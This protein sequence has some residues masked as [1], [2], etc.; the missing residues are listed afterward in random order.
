MN[1]KSIK[2]STVQLPSEFDTIFQEDLRWLNNPESI[3]SASILSLPQIVTF[4]T[5]ESLNLRNPADSSA[6]KTSEVPSEGDS[7]FGI[8]L[9][10]RHQGTNSLYLS[11]SFITPNI[12]SFEQLKFNFL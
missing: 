11:T 6:K 10:F 2:K 4:D 1:S 3:A 12:I 8:I 5:Y 7:S 9:E